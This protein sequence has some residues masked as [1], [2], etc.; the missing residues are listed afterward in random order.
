MFVTVLY[1]QT[2]TRG[3]KCVF[4]ILCTLADVSFFKKKEIPQVTQV[5]PGRKKQEKV[6]AMFQHYF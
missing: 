6:F 1:S 2:R 5:R 4:C 3:G